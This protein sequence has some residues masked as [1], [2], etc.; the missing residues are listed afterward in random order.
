MLPQELLTFAE[1]YK[2]LFLTA[3]ILGTILGMGGATI[4]DILF[5]RFLKDFRISNKEHEVLSVL[6]NVVMSALLLIII[7][8][9]FLFLSDPEGYR[10]N[11]AFVF[12][13]LVVGIVTINGIALHLLV[14][15]Y[16]IHLNMRKK[17]QRM[18]RNWH[19]LA[20]ALGGISFASWYTAFFTA[21]L[22]RYLEGWM[23][24]DLLVAYLIVLAIGIGGSQVVERHLNKKASLL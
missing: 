8:G 17:H 21:M 3:H 15:P 11:P 13:T 10:S 16:L 1:T 23:V 14:A 6:K 24:G 7:S 22:K 4:S 20:F 12:K 18:S 9:I 2:P 5:F 19:H